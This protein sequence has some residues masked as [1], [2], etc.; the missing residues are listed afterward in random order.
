V[1]RVEGGNRRYRIDADSFL[2][3]L[4]GMRGGVRD[5]GD[6]EDGG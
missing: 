1:V 3:V 2:V 6:E 5:E 4:G